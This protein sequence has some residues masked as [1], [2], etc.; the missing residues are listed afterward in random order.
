MKSP[1]QSSIQVNPST[2]LLQLS[3]LGHATLCGGSQ[4]CV[5]GATKVAIAN[6]GY[7]AMAAKWKWT[8]SIADFM[9]NHM[10]VAEINGWSLV[11]TVCW[12][13]QPHPCHSCVAKHS[14]FQLIRPVTLKKRKHGRERNHENCGHPFLFLVDVFV[15][16]FQ[17]RIIFIKIATSNF[18]SH[19][20]QDQVIVL[21][22]SSQ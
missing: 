3:C 7:H 11:K 10:L 19:S 9:E 4:E 2:A 14:N 16:R 22:Y 1:Q 20:F 17:K 13:C 6:S 21:R 8:S 12:E 15:I 18:T 5:L